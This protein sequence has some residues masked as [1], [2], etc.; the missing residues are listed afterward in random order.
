MAGWLDKA[1]KYQV[2]FEVFAIR[3]VNYHK[4]WDHQFILFLSGWM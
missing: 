3:Q 4:P 1:F 2:Q